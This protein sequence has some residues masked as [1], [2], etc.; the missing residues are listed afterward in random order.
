MNCVVAS[1]IIGHTHIFE[2]DF[3]IYFVIIGQ[4]LRCNFDNKS[5]SLSRINI[6]SIKQ[7]LLNLLI[8]YS[9]F[10]IKNSSTTQIYALFDIIN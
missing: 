5:C 8:A 10:S 9:A 1:F 7:N 2:Y 6:W 4:Q 3:M